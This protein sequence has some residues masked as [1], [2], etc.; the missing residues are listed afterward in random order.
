MRDTISLNRVRRLRIT[1]GLVMLA[2]MPAAPGAAGP[3][4]QRLDGGLDDFIEA[5]LKQGL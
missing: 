4:E 5:S 1:A 2:S 3:I